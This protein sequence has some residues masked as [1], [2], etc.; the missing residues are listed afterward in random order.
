MSALDLL[1][2]L[3]FRGAGLQIG[4]GV[5]FC[6]QDQYGHEDDM[7]VPPPSSHKIPLR[8]VET[9]STAAFGGTL[10]GLA[11]FPAGW[12]S[13]A[14]LFVAVA[15]L[16]GRPVV[17]PIP[18]AR[19]IFVV[20]GISLGAVVTPETLKGVVAWPLSIAVL[21][22]AMT[23]ATFATTGYL[24]IVHG[25]DAMSAFFATVPGAL[26]Q[27][28][29]LAAQ[30]NADLRGVAIVQTVRVFILTIGVPIGLSL[31]GLAGPAPVLAPVLVE[32][33]LRELAILVVSSTF[34]A[35]ILQLLRFPGGLIFGAMLASAVLHGG[36]LIKVALPWWVAAAA[37]CAL[38]A[39]TG[40][41]FANTSMR[42]LLN[43]LGAAVGAFA[44][45][46]TVASV[47]VL[48]LIEVTSFR[49]ADIVVSFAPGALDAMMILALALQLDPVYVGAHHVARFLLISLWLPFAA[50][51]MAGHAPT[52]K[53]R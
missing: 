4:S 10:F 15:A 49:A 45:A 23:C 29:A 27:V 35:I 28:V 8:V 40:S 5:A 1:S 11:G 44:V 39:V 53:N 3:V 9:L 42:L 25:W 37:M 33:P 51:M 2:S 50:R 17:V 21:A 32:H 47:F 34:S 48:A 26:S 16:A 30:N 36:G 43:Y 7:S 13:G 24:R 52:D 22:V 19:V 38:G 46:I 41:R 12:L 20:I 14:M 18:I 31:L 6:E